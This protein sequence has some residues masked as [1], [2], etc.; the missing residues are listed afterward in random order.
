MCTN[1]YGQC[2]SL[3]KTLDTAHMNAAVWSFVRVY[4]V[5]S[6]EV[7]FAVETLLRVQSAFVNW[8]YVEEIKKHLPKLAYLW[9]ALW[10]GTGKWSSSWK[11]SRRFSIRCGCHLCSKFQAFEGE[12]QS[13]VQWQRIGQVRDVL[14]GGGGRD[15]KG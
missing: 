2:A 13:G 6:L 12:V 15:G 8:T 3:Y 14:E 11:A 5:M 7:R 4:S 9:T 1:V 10:P